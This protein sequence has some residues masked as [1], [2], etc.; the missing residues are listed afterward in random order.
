MSEGYKFEGVWIK[1][2]KPSEGLERANKWQNGWPTSQLD[3]LFL[4]ATVEWLTS[5]WVI[6]LRLAY[7]LDRVLTRVFMVLLMSMV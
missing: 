1:E 4:S 3:R 6:E 7:Y 2:E 5:Q